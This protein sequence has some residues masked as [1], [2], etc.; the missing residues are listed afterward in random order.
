[1]YQILG[2]P[3]AG[4][5]EERTGNEQKLDVR[6][7]GLHKLTHKYSTILTIHAVLQTDP[8]SLLEK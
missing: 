5:G 1:M 4:V 3:A 6:M 8:K 7:P 2:F